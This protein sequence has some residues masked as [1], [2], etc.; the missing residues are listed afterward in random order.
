VNIH[1]PSR[2]IEPEYLH[3][4]AA[5]RERAK[6]CGVEMRIRFGATQH[7]LSSL[8]C[9][10]ALVA[11][12]GSIPTEKT[13]SPTPSVEARSNAASLLYDLLGDE[14]HVSKLLIIKRDRHELHEVIS[15]IAS[16]ANEARKGLENLARNDPT[17]NLKGAALPPGEQQ[18]RESESKARAHE[19][20]HSSGADYEFKL[21]LAQAE[22]LAYAEHLAK[23]AAEHE[24]DRQQ[25]KVF[26]E[27]SARM[28]YLHGQ[29]VALMRSPPTSSR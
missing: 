28:S 12:C 1:E 16:T 15:R 22:A 18:A 19:L 17:L 24:P 26:A 20:L 27:I 7:A 5:K 4:F 10:V 9:M 25:L 6:M 14:Q 11:G 21:L 3:S 8:L 2:R 23:V 29:V 13:P